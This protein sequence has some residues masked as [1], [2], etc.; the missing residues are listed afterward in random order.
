MDSMYDQHGAN[1]FFCSALFEWEPVDPQGLCRFQN[2]MD[3]WMTDF[4]LLYWTT[5]VDQILHVLNVS[6]LLTAVV[7]SATDRTRSTIIWRCR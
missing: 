6:S 3:G 4:G 2:N 1:T 5:T 7:T